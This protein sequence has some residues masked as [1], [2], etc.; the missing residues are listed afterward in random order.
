MIEELIEPRF[1]GSNLIIETGNET[2]VYDSQFLVAALCI[3]VAKSDGQISE[4]ETEKMLE[5]VGQHFHLESSESLSLLTRAM[6]DLA[7]NPDLTSLL[8]QLSTVL[9][10]QEKEDVAVM[11]LKVVAANGRKEAEEM[12]AL[13]MAAEIIDISPDL[14]HSAFDRYFEDTRKAES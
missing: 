11:L 14:V 2:E 9:T 10:A 13:S 6:A 3:F 8:R 12:E 7:D 1:E 5:L 4:D